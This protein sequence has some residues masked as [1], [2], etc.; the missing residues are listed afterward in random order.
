MELW[1]DTTDMDTIALG[2]RLG[3]VYG[4]TTNPTIIANSGRDLPTVAAA[5]LE[6]QPGPL[7]LQVVKADA[8]GMVEEGLALHEISPRVIVKVPLTQEGLI[9]MRSLA[10]SGVRIMATAAFHPNHLLLAASVGAHYIAP[11]LGRMIKAGEDGFE[12]LATM[13][14]IHDKHELRIKVLAAALQ[15]ADQVAA[16]AQLGIH[17]VTLKDEIFSE[18]VGDHP[19]TIK[20][21]E[22]FAVD[23]TAAFG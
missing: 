16:C 23:W 19:Q 2:R 3:V 10:E 11:Y 8:E 18:F 15:D 13:M 7:T 20:A 6:A 12:V 21:V 17:A 14:T 9:A 1:L 5:L 4:V 22:T